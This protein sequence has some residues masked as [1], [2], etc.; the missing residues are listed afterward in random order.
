MKAAVSR[1][2]ARVLPDTE[3]IVARV[4]A[5]GEFILTLD[6]DCS[7]D[8][9]VVLSLLEAKDQG[10]VIVA[11]RYVQFGHSQS[12]GFRDLLSRILNR[13]FRTLLSVPVRDL[14]SGIIIGSTR[15]H[16]IAPPLE[17]V[18]IGYTWY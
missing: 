13:F 3:E 9:A 12:P 17:R 10:D 18:E 15:Y 11:S 1:Y 14:T 8:P 7:H 6:A 4:Q 5:R 16:D 2:G